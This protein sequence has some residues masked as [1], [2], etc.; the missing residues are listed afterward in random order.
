MS[1]VLLGPFYIV[2]M[3]IVP[4]FAVIVTGF[5][6][7]KLKIF[8]QRFADGL[9]TFVFYF[10]LPAL[11][12]IKISTVP[13][14]LIFSKDMWVF[15]LVII[16]I[17]IF[18]YWVTWGFNVWV[19]KKTIDIAT[20][21][22][23]CATVA[24]S[25]LLGVPILLAL[26]GHSVLLPCAIVIILVTFL[27]YIP[28]S[29][30]LSCCH[31]KTRI[32]SIKSTLKVWGLFIIS[33]PMMWMPI[34]AIL[35][36]VNGWHV[37]HQLT[38]YLTYLQYAVVPCALFAAGLS[39]TFLS[40]EKGMWLYVINISFMK[41]IVMPLLAVV[42]AGYFHLPPKLG[43]IAIILSSIPTA[44]SVL[45]LTNS[46]HVKEVHAAKLVALSTIIAAVTVTFWVMI[47]GMIYPSYFAYYAMIPWYASP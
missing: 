36:S 1:T 30:I 19:L 16:C 21:N 7:G 28:S 33:A 46:Y 3:T 2:F 40:P 9:L 24:N 32:T 38:A 22:A 27:S 39:I 47:A 13:P 18:A 25:A 12:F 35:C 8:D 17:N 43:I 44:K 31:K 23:M 10:A 5:I 45:T 14:I 11:L 26:F 20:V 6:A 29:I 42:L 37:S 15:S 4:V 41:L 34:L